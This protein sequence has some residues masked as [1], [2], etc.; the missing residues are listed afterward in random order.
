MGSRL[1]LPDL[2]WR[3]WDATYY[4]R[5][6]GCLAAGGGTGCAKQGLWTQRHGLA[7]SHDAKSQYTEIIE[8]GFD[9]AAARPAILV[10]DGGGSLQGHGDGP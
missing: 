10:A 2:V 1:L 4:S 3:P 7:V 8:Q 5:S 6:W 9:A